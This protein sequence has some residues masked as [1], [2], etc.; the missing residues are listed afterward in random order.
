MR[1]V[2]VDWSGRLQ[3]ASKFI[4]TAVAAGGELLALEADRDRTQVGDHLLQLALADPALVV[5][6]DFAFSLPLWFLDRCGFESGRAVPEPVAEGWLRDCPPPFWG[7]HRRG[8]GP[9][10]QHRR[11]ELDVAPHAKSVFQVGGAGAVGTGSLRGFPLLRRLRA[12]GFSIW[13]FDP[14]R[15]P[16]ALEIF[17]RLLTGPVIKSRAAERERHLIER[18]WPIEA[19][20]TEDAFDAAVSALVMDRH[21]AALAALPAV[22]DPVIRREGR[23]WW[24]G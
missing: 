24:P 23:I 6:I 11:T 15:P 19:A 5:G 22:G 4:W 3:G 21:A 17:P 8:R 7:R 14:P 18:G 1:V 9:E 12:E 10:P 13:P 2:A 16:V 20:V